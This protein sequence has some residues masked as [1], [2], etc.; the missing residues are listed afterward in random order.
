METISLD[1]SGEG[2]RF[3]AARKGH[4]TPIDGNGE[5]AV[6]PVGLLLESLTSCAASDVVEILRKGRQPL[7]GLSV[8]ASAERRPEP[9]RYL[10]RV[11]LEFTISGEVE[12][13]KAERAVRLSFEKY[14]SVYHSLREDLKLEWSIVY[15]D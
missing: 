7:E 4:P 6:T 15:G 8:H 11:T 5:V 12:P 14:C 13:K 1:W 10:T 2:L 9:P 3:E